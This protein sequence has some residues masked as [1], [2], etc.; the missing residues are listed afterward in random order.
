MKN[1]RK[2]LAAVAI[3]LTT[4]V[5][6]QATAQYGPLSYSVMPYDKWHQN[7]GWGV[8]LCWWAN[9]CGKWSDSKIDQ[10]VTW[11]V[12]PEGLNCNIFRYNIPGGDDPNNANCT[13]HHMDSG[14]GRR[15]EMEGF[16][17]SSSDDYDWTRDAAQRK[18]MLKIKEKRPDAIFEAFSN[19][20]PYYMTYS[21]CC[22][23]NAD[24]NKD[25]LKPEYY[26]EFAHYLVDV[27]K[28]YK[29][30]YGIEFKTLEPFNEPNTNYWYA[31]GD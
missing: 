11:L 23:G 16:K 27:C 5:P 30:E 2:L 3:A 28:H 26:E 10:L 24:A 7:E 13:L 12:S 22:A 9:M 20:P 25:N 4:A 15:A 1:K 6:Q 8:S 29:D 31:G 17:T 14:K 18:I 19:T 21:G